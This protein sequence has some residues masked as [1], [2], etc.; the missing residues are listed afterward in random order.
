MKTRIQATKDIDTLISKQY[1]KA[2]KNNPKYEFP[3]SLSII[4]IK[5]Q[6]LI[7]NPNLKKEHKQD[8]EMVSKTELLY[9]YI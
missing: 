1:D 2:I 5:T 8:V 9:N 7:L 6:D 4:I 3:F